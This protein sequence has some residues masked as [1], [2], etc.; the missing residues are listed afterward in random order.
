MTTNPDII[1]FSRGHKI[2]FCSN[3]PDFRDLSR[4]EPSPFQST[5]VN[6]KS[7]LYA[8]VIETAATVYVSN[9]LLCWCDCGIVIWVVVGL[10]VGLVICLN[11]M[12]KEKNGHLNKAL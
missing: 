6:V 5:V 12:Q 8:K 11:Y 2:N 4:P 7:L 10:I 9:I 1:N 3:L